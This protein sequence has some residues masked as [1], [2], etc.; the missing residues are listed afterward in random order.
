LLPRQVGKL[1]GT[2]RVVVVHALEVEVHRLEGPFGSLRG[3]Q[4]V[5]ARGDD[6]KVLGVGEVDEKAQDYE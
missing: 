6:V 2:E 3:E 5:D 4:D 1:G